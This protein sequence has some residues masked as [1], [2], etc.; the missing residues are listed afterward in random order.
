MIN[1]KVTKSIDFQDVFMKNW[2]TAKTVLA[3]LQRAVKNRIIKLVIGF[4]INLGDELYNN[5]EDDD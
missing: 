4:V 5:Y 3:V 2:P 1:A